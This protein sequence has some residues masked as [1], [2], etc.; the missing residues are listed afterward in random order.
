[1]LMPKIENKPPVVHHY[2]RTILASLLGIFAL[3]LILSSIFTVW[4]N[5][6]LTDTD[7]YMSS[8]APLVTKPEVQ[9]FVVQKASETLLKDQDVTEVSSKLLTP[10]QVAGKSPEELNALV[11]EVVES[12]IQQVVKSPS[13]AQLW[14]ETNR[15]AHEAII[16]Q[17]ESDSNTLT[18]DLS[19]LVLG[20][21]DQLKTTS[22]GPVVDQIEIK[23]E[24]A[25]LDLKGGAIDQIHSN[26]K[27]FQNG[28][29]VTVILAAVAAVLAV[30]VSVHHIKTLRRILIGTGII[31]LLVALAIRAPS[32]IKINGSRDSIEQKAAIAIAETLF[33]N[34]QVACITIGIVC[35]VAAVGSKFYEVWRAKKA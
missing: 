13:F 9:D 20:I 4:L 6:T 2:A 21:V 14:E 1:M 30:V 18:L 35:I 25:K 32:I 16:N 27:N 34:L 22:L 8:V 15:T 33:H 3:F 12:S 23:P 28:T 10:E 24:N 29:I 5:R 7:V 11:R 31:A 17:L 19:P 26:Y